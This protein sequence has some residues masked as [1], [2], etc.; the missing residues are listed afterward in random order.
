MIQIFLKKIYIFKSYKNEVKM[1]HFFL[2]SVFQIFFQFFK[3]FIIKY[4]FIKFLYIHIF[5]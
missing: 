3:F 5:T 2:K 4:N 1:K